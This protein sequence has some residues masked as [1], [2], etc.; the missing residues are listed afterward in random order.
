[1][2]RDKILTGRLTGQTVC[3]V[4]KNRLSEIITGQAAPSRRCH[5]VLTGQA[6]C[7][8]M[9]STSDGDYPQTAQHTTTRRVD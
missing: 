8:G 9:I 5:G 7:A 1:M 4:I 2:P 6:G 3:P